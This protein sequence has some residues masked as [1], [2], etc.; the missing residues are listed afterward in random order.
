MIPATPFTARTPQK[1]CLDTP[2][3]QNQTPSGS[4]ALAN[5]RLLYRGSLSLPDSYMS[6]DGLTFS[7][8]L[9]S[10]MKHHLLENPLALALESMRGRQ[11]LRFVGTVKLGD[12]WLD[13]TGNVEMDIHP[14][15]VLSKIYF[16]NI[17]CLLPYPPAST[18]QQATVPLPGARSEFGVKIAL[19]D[20]D[21]PETTHVVV[22]GQIISPTA[23][24]VKLRVARITPRPSQRPA[25]TRVPRPDDPTPRRPPVTSGRTKGAGANILK[26]TVSSSSTALAFRLGHDNEA[27]AK[28]Q[29]LV[30][31]NSSHETSK[32]LSGRV[33]KVP[34]LPGKETGKGKE[35]E[36]VFGSR[37]LSQK[38][39]NGDI[40]GRHTEEKETDVERANK[41]SIRK[42]TLEHLCK[43][44]DPTFQRYVD[45][46]HPE[47]KEIWA[48]IYRGVG[49]ALRAHM[50]VTTLEM[51]DILPLIETHSR[52]YV[53]EP[54]VGVARDALS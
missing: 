1:T 29:K 22:F 34:S 47:F 23:C 28:K 51:H 49:F 17:F 39:S 6:L 20:T 16:E 52:M 11:C 4:S 37:P 5:Y 27:P 15:A 42:A 12:V 50:K 33:F 25:Q 2:K 19:G 24:S 48:A 3:S 45:R 41:N 7:A 35:K 38:A 44:K 54:Q 26:R 30:A 8:R 40:K 31:S 10:P 46:A 13:E 53:G 32:G 14:R 43:T 21:G 18:S 36:D 9:E